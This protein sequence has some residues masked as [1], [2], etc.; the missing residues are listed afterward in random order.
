MKKVTNVFI[1][2]AL[3]MVCATAVWAND[4]GENEIASIANAKINL[5]QAVDSAL[6]SVPGKALRAELDA[7]DDGNVFL[8]EVVSDNQIYEVSIDAATGK[9]LGKRVDPKDNNDE[10]DERD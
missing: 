9:V 2:L 1:V 5:T 7:E 6:K 10:E 8:V 4:D 3:T